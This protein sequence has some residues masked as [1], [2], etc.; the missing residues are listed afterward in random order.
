MDDLTKFAL[1]LVLA[2]VLAAATVLMLVIFA[3]LSPWWL[4]FTA[5]PFFIPFCLTI[6]YVAGRVTRKT[7]R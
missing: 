1:K 4:L 2:T 7:I 6:L 3:G 5:A